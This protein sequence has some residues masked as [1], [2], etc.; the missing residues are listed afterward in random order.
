MGAGNGRDGVN[1]ILMSE[2]ECISTQTRYKRP[3][4]SVI[5]LWKQDVERFHDCV[6]NFSAVFL[7]WGLRANDWSEE[8]FISVD[9]FDWPIGMAATTKTR[10]FP[11]VGPLA[12]TRQELDRNSPL[13]SLLPPGYHLSSVDALEPTLKF[14]S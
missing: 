4:G 14:A 2:P 13:H 11:L 9:A 7:G 12:G 5:L 1:N 3:S 8:S 6:C 10:P